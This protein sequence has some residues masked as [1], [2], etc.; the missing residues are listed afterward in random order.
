M[1]IQS[2]VARVKKEYKGYLRQEHPDW[3]ESTVSTHVSDAF[4]AYQNNIVW[5]FWKCLEIEDSMAAAHKEIL[6]YLT[7]EVMSDRAKERANGYYHD[8]VMLKGFMDKNGG[9]R[10]YIGYEFDCEAAIYTYSKQVYTG[11]ITSGDAVKAM[12]QEVPCFG[13]GSHRFM[14]NLF[15]AMMEG[16]TYRWKANMETTIYF[17]EHIGKDFGKEKMFNALLATKNNIIYYY[18]QTGNK[19]ISLRKRCQKLAQ[20]SG[21]DIPFGDEIFEG[22]IPKE[23]TDA[24]LTSNASAVR[25]WVYAAGDGSVNWESD[26][27]EGIMAIGWD[28]M[29]DLSLYGS[30]EELREKMQE[31]YG[32]GSSHS[33]SVLALWQFANEIKPGDV[34]F[35]KKGRKKFLGRG[36]VEGEY[37]YDPQRG[38]YGNIRKVKWTDKGEWEHP[39]QGVMKTLTDITP[40]TDYLKNCKSC[41]PRTNL[42]MR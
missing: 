2:T 7:D 5:P 29:G 19:S 6:T 11:E 10:Q 40:Y 4:Y 38:H 1:D 20:E 16:R 31:Q 13:E 24:V 41:L 15:S 32:S 14:V 18:E 34:V 27:A 28:N 17:I 30:K 8:L 35:V 26:Y 33:N 22:I 23:S 25:Y 36:I 12:C 42:K 21:I 37:L 9:V 3:T 39:D